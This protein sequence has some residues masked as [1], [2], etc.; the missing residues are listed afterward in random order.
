MTLPAVHMRAHGDEN[1]HG[2]RG[3]QEQ[4]PPPAAGVADDRDR[5]RLVR[6][7]KT[8]QVATETMRIAWVAPSVLTLALHRVRPWAIGCATDGR[9][10][11]AS[12]LSTGSSTSVPAALA[13]R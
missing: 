5:Q 3:H 1:R 12:D 4:P 2:D 6:A 8:A 9:S 13:S 10:R 11:P 7:R